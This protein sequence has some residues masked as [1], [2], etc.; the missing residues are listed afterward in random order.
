MA[1]FAKVSGSDISTFIS[2]VDIG[3]FLSCR[4]IVEKVQNTNYLVTTGQGI[5]IL[6]LFEKPDT[7][8]ELRFFGAYRSLS[9]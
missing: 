9:F 7:V 3:K 8:K 1:V 2:G 5:Y 6:A 4:E